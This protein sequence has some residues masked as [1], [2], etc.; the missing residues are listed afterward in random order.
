MAFT[1]ADITAIRDAAESNLLKAMK[2]QTA[3]GG[4]PNTT[5]S[6]SVDHDGF[7]KRQRDTIDWCNEQ[8]AILQPVWAE[9][10]AEFIG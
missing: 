9:T 7:C 1:V 4:L 10:S 3:L 8:I 2:D 5:G 6:D